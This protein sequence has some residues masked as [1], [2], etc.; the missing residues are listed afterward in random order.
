MKLTAPILINESA[1]VSRLCEPITVGIPIPKGVVT[2]DSQVAL[3]DSGEVIPVQTK[4]LVS[5]PDKSIKW[6]L[7]DFQCPVRA[8][9]S[10]KISLKLASEES[11]LQ[12]K[13]ICIDE[14]DGVVAVDTGA[15]CFY[16]PTNVFMPF[17]KVIIAEQNFLSTQ[18]SA[19]V[20]TDS[21]GDESTP[22]ITAWEWETRGPLR[23]TMKLSGK[24]V[25][26]GQGDLPFFTA[27]VSF[28]AGIST[29]RV[30]FTVWNPKAAK[31]PGGLW[32]LG[33]PS[34]FYFKDISMHLFSGF[35]HPSS[36]H[37]NDTTSG[38]GE[39]ISTSSFE[40]YQDSS[41][42]DNWQS[43]N[44]VNRNNEVGTTFKGYRITANKEEIKCGERAEPSIIVENGSQKIGVAIQQF[45]QNFPKSL[46]VEQDKIS[47]RFFPHQY[48]DIFELQGGERK[49][50]TAYLDFQNNSQPQDLAGWV[51]N[52]LGVKSTPE[53]YANSN[54]VPYLVP[55]CKETES[56]F[57]SLIEPAIKGGNTFY[58]RRE[59]IDEYGWRNFGEWYADH[60][61]IGYK[62][63]SPLISH[64]NNQYDGIY[65]TLC[66]YMKG[67]DSRWFKL[68]DQLCHHVRDI[69]I[70]RTDE[71]KP[72]FNNGLFWHTEHYLD[73]QTAT[74][75]CYSKRHAEFRNLNCYGGGTANSHNYVWGLLYHYYLTGE[76]ESK[77]TV[78][79]LAD[80]I[81]KGIASETT[82]TSFL[83]D[84]LRKTRMAIKNLVKGQAI[85]E[86]VKVYGV[87]GPGRASGNSVSTLLAA[88]ELTK[89][90]K[91]IL[92]AEN[93]IVTCVHPADNIDKMD[94]MD[95]ENRWMY[96]IFL[97]SLGRY[98]D[99]T[100][101]NPNAQL[102][103]YARESLLHYSNW[104][105]DNEYIYLETPDKLEYPN[106]TWAAQEIRKCNVLLYAAKYGD[107]KDRQMFFEKA[108]FFCT[109]CVKQLQKYETRSL[110]RPI[111]LLLQNYLMPSYFLK[112]PADFFDEMSEQVL[113]GKS[114]KKRPI[115]H[116]RTIRQIFNSIKNISVK[117]E[118]TF[119]LWRI[120]SRL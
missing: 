9:E 119:L 52:P 12:E 90:K 83:I 14:K 49:T 77:Q 29:C 105:V 23:A 30:D 88:Y 71:D 110:T 68:G 15:A 102:R 6:L 42:G 98:L 65:G 72:E 58:D 56:D 35:E 51:H 80:F 10:K 40:I 7:L 99:L 81:M 4:T 115:S 41:G 69:D 67:G 17:S 36:I 79:D 117:N 107:E 97:Q 64:Y 48:N 74:H 8:M 27:R 96:T 46:E 2:D 5:W 38:V 43:R 47:L 44:H 106:E 95:I 22:V 57:L 93:L 63:V 59:I 112:T 94:L 113:S 116:I 73:V 61:A 50:H 82:L 32:D 1:G 114:Y 62:G 109:G 101:E 24:F 76:E 75:R 53:W 20:L 34:S 87:H 3:Y 85:V 54:A 60:E 89:E 103:E 100:V 86:L 25:S 39:K 28:F 26:E 118:F 18:C 104:M 78:L 33:D 21:E 11:P 108:M 70:Y 13:A 37:W 92:S 91:Y 111:T 84:V 120:K 66:Q 19:T 45:W 16:I 31:H 55:E